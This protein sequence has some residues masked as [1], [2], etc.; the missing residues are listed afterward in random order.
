MQCPYFK[1]INFQKI[2]QLNDIEDDYEKNNNLIPVKRD[3]FS[4]EDSIP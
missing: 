4:F 2:V 3:I 1:K